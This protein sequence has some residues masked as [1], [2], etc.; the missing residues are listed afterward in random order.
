[1]NF[2]LPRG[3][4]H[5]GNHQRLNHANCHPSSLHTSQNTQPQ[6]KKSSCLPHPAE[7]KEKKCPGQSAINRENLL[8]SANFQ[9][10]KELLNDDLLWVL[11]LIFALRNVK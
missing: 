6:A 2:L 1:M 3:A 8:R 4:T 11:D 5:F 9:L 10:K 7:K